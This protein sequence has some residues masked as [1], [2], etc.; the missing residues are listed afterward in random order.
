MSTSFNLN[1]D[2]MGYLMDVKEVYHRYSFNK[3]IL[4]FNAQLVTASISENEIPYTPSP[5]R[6]TWAKGEALV[7][8]LHPLPWS[9]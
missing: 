7:D 9:F 1:P 8:G 3:A 5:S 4:N 2:I 6:R